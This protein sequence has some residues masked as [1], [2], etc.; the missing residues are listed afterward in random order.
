V[1]EVEDVGVGQ[2][3]CLGGIDEDDLPRHTSGS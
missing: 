2:I 3:L 1:V